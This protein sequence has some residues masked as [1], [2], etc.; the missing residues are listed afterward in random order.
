MHRNPQRK[1]SPANVGLSMDFVATNRSKSAM[2]VL[3]R[4][5]RD[6]AGAGVESPR[7]GRL[8]GG[9]DGQRPVSHELFCRFCHRGS[10]RQGG[11]LRNGVVSVGELLVYVRG[12]VARV[13]NG[14]QTP[15][16]GRSNGGGEIIFLLKP[17]PTDV[18]TDASRHP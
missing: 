10:S 12:E 15:I 5:L 9:L 8:S 13:S 1:P 11:L 17:E 6:W 14:Q 4:I 2:Y 16:M 7:G 3:T 18:M